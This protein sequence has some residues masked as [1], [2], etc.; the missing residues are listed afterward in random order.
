MA[1]LEFWNA[2]NNWLPTWEKDGQMEIKGVR[3]YQQQGYKG[4]TNGK[5]YYNVKA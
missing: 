2:R 4:C 3:M 1:K 5:K